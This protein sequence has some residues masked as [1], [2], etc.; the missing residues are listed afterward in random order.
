ML[1]EW[2]YNP[3]GAINHLARGGHFSASVGMRNGLGQVIGLFTYHEKDC[4]LQGSRG[5]RTVP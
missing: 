1:S 2:T 4:D 5:K 3:K